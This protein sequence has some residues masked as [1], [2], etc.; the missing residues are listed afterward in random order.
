MTDMEFRK[1]SNHGK[2]QIETRLRIIEP[3][4]DHI[5]RELHEATTMSDR[6]CLD[7]DTLDGMQHL[8]TEVLQSSQEGSSA[9]TP[10]KSSRF[11][12]NTLRA[13]LTRTPTSMASQ[14]D[15]RN[16]D[17]FS[18]KD[19][20][21]VLITE[22]K[23]PNTD[24]EEND[25]EENVATTTANQTDEAT[26]EETRARCQESSRTPKETTDEDY[27]TDL[28]DEDEEEEDETISYYKSVCEQ[29]GLAPV[30]YFIRHMKD[31]TIKM[32]YRGLGPDAI[33]AIALSLRE[34]ITLDRLDIS[35]NWIGTEGS[36]VMCRL[37]E[38]NDYITNIALKENKIG[39]DGC[40]HVAKMIHINSGL[41]RLDLSGNELDDKCAEALSLALESNR[42][43]RELNLSHNN[44][45]EVGAQFIGM[46]IGA[47]ENLD[48]LNL[49][50]NHLR[51]HGG[52]ELAKGLKENIRLKVCNL[53]WNGL[54]T[55]AGL[56][57][58]DALSLN[59]SLLELDISGNRLTYAVATKLAKVL[60]TNDVIR[61]LKLGNNCI[62]SAGAIALATV[63]NNTENCE[64]QQLDLT[65]VPVEYE[66]LRTVEEIQ[67][68]KPHFAVKHGP[69]MR[70]GNTT[71]DLSKAAIDMDIVR[72][73]PVVILKDLAVP[74]DKTRLKESLLKCQM[75]KAGTIYFGNF[76][77]D[78]KQTEK[79]EHL[80]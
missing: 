4:P 66:F 25:D 61:V 52:I 14:G 7:Q 36:R 31:T 28:D 27:D 76:I 77:P 19:Y 51:E 30:K 59:Q 71:G 10:S 68:K 32:R 6:H 39:S 23:I 40:L 78:S 67:R 72:K 60:A 64:L 16:D 58:A 11:P 63:V 69:V 22:L 37:L 18:S 46:S 75:N 29:L 49:S 24:A 62:T 50:W 57:L 13:T 26:V 41:R 47:N 55:Q 33:K 43:L 74:C 45:T 8:S 21:N 1:V 9:R 80:S 17:L 48:V 5:S 3:T 44:F 70:A 73:Q 65:D 54:A 42:N 20:S 79:A 38:E 53:S 34:N 12:M 2:E 35:G 56:A 15:D